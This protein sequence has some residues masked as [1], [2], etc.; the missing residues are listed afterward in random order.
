MKFELFT[1]VA[2]NTDLR[3]YRLRSGDIATVVESYPGRPGQ[4]AGYALEVLSAVGDT[5][6]RGHL[7]DSQIVPFNANEPLHVRPLAKPSDSL[8]RRLGDN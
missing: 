5:V 6:E 3:Q 8:W 1:R 2:L 4:E 7:P